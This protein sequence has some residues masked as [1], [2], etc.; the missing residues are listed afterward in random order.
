VPLILHPS[1]VS[2]MAK[3]ELRNY[4]ISA[5]P[6]EVFSCLG[7]MRHNHLLICSILENFEQG[8]LVIDIDLFIYF[9]FPFAPSACFF[10]TAWAYVYFSVGLPVMNEA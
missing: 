4:D 5:N 8:F 6:Y 7:D 9:T 2:K 10:F 1:T 3:V